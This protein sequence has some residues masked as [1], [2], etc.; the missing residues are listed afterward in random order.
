M[1]QNFIQFV[2]QNILHVHARR[3]SQKRMYVKNENNPHSFIGDKNDDFQEFLKLSKYNINVLVSGQGKF[4]EYNDLK[5]I[6]E[7]KW[8]REH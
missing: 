8:R 6:L 4:K 2:C 5:Q 1:G 7:S 3:H